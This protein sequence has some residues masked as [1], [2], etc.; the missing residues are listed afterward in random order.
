MEN[1]NHVKSEVDDVNMDQRGAGIIEEMQAYYSRRAPIYDSSMGYDDPKYVASLAPVI[2]FV[3][4][5]LRH[6]R[7][8]EVACGPGFWTEHL[9]RAGCEVVASDYNESMIREAQ[10][11]GFRAEAVQFV[12]ADAYAFPFRGEA[13]RGAF[14]C[15]WLA[16]VPK[17]RMGGFLAGLRTMLSPDARVVFCD[18]LPRTDSIEEYDPEGNHVQLRELPDGSRYRVI[19]H[20]LSDEEML[21]LFSGHAAGEVEIRKYP[22]LRR[23]VVAYSVS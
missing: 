5:Q 6:R 16:H 12:V 15:D 8:L 18:Q 14:A 1:G 4:E 7:V 11:R 21:E 9:I 3:Q 10:T 17:D 22:E 2:S 19:K 13:F 23:I 20:F